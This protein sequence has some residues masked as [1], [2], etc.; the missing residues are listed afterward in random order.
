MILNIPIS[1]DLKSLYFHLKKL[2]APNT[3]EHDEIILHNLSLS[4]ILE[5]LM[6]KVVALALNQTKHPINE[7]PELDQLHV[8]LHR[9]QL[10]V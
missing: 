7:A 6:V 1:L 8:P 2:I 4:R 9:Y 5:T 10:I 3:L